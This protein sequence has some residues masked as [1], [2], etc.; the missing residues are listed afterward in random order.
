MGNRR[1]LNNL[2]V[3]LQPLAMFSFVWPEA[4]YTLAEAFATVDW[5][6][7]VKVSGFQHGLSLWPEF[8]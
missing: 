8:I 4:L 6:S 1:P 5:E 3:V 2:A 7:G